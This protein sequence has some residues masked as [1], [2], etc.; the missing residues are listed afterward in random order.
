MYNG[1]MD[2]ARL[3]SAL[4]SLF[5]TGLIYHAFTDYMRDYELILVV[6]TDPKS[7]IRPYFLRYLF[8]YCVEADV[9]SAVMTEVW[10]RSLDDRLIEIDTVGN[11]AEGYVWGVRWQLLYPGATLVTDS[12]RAQRWAASVRI[13]FH[14]VRIEANAHTLTLVFS[15]LEVSKVAIGYKPFVIRV[16][17]AARTAPFPLSGKD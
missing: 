10:P 16:D 6:T 12:E 9:E 15:D 5:D 3:Q 1:N 13:D 7:G 11:D 2:E 17:V 14:E 4:R 8:K